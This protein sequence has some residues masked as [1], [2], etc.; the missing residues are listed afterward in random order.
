MCT[1]LGTRLDLVD[2]D[3]KSY[4]IN[5]HDGEK[6][7]IILDPSH[8]IKLIRNT[9]GNIK[10]IY[11]GTHEIKWQYFVDLASL[12][13]NEVFGLTHKMNKRH[14]QFEDRKMHVRTAVETLSKSTADSLQFLNENGV[15]GFAGADTTIKFIRM[16]DQLWDICDSKRIRNDMANKFKSAMNEKNAAEIFEF[17]IEMKTYILSLNVKSKKTG[18]MVSIVKSD[19][20]TG[21][22]GFI[23]NI[24]SI[25]A[26]Y[27]E[28]VQNQHWMNFIAT[29]RL[30]QDHL[31]MFFGS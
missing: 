19:Y 17:L 9:L 30:S 20:K 18:L 4:F 29:Y 14:I 24:N 7:Y 1:Y 25:T 2:G 6:I 21:F 28:Y 15:D 12:S 23:L 22:R 11:E 31:E 26:M 16:F 10:T 5:P 27:K 3:F 13:G 8:A